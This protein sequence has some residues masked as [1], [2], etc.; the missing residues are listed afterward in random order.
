MLHNVLGGQ[1]EHPLQEIIA[2]KTWLVLRDLPELTGENLNDIGRVFDLPNLRRIFVKRTQNFPAIF[3]AFHVGKI[4]HPPFLPESE[5]VFLRLLQSYGGVYLLQTCGLPLDVLPTGK[6]GGGR[7][8]VDNAPLE[9][10]IGIY[11]LQ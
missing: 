4:L 7:D 11:C 2:G 10:A 3:L 5:L 6:P 1:V 9:K 8:P